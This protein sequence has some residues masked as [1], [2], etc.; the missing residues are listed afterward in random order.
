[1]IGADTKPTSGMIESFNSL[2]ERIDAQLQKLKVI[3]D[4]QIPPFNE[5][6][7]ARQKPAIDISVKD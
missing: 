3:L 6:A 1:I 5:A 4:K 2:S 7:K